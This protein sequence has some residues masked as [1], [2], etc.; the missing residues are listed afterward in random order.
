MRQELTRAIKLTRAAVPGSYVLVGLQMAEDLGVPRERLLKGI[1]LDPAR[2]DQASVRV[3]VLQCARLVARVWRATHNPA[4]GYEFGLRLNLPA[5]GSVAQ[6]MM[7]QATF[8]E[9]MAFGLRYG[10]LRNPVVKL[11]LRVDGETAI[12]DARETLPLGPLRRFAIDAVLIGLVRLGR[13]LSGAMRPQMELRFDCPE[14]AH[15]A[16]FRHRLPPVRFNAGA[17]ELRIP[18]EYLQRPMHTRDAAAA[19]V[20]ARQCEAELALTD[21][22]AD[23][24]ERVRGLLAEAGGGHPDLVSIARRLHTSPRTLKRRLQR[25]GWTFL[26]LLDEARRRDS[27]RLLADRVL[28]VAEVAQRLGYES[29]ASFTR[30]FRKWTGQTPSAWRATAPQS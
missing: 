29:P 12:V 15:Y 6:G 9:T 21:D 18:A 25:E 2:L 16:G 8:G 11:S 4:L 7:S 24:A 30:A 19:S 3:P 10:A 1:G 14:P 27:L 28:G 23:T 17:N 20:V 5:H 26:Q 22:A 13:Q